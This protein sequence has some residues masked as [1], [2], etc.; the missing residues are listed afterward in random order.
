M[1]PDDADFSFT[2]DFEKGAGDPRR[3][4]DAASALVD[5]FESI[6][7]ALVNVLDS[8][9]KTVVVLEDVES[10][11]LKV[12]LRNLLSG[13]PDESLKS[14]EWKKAVGHYL[15]KA[16]YLALEFCNDETG[17][18]ERLDLLREQI[19]ELGRD[20]NIRHLPDYAPIHEGRLLASLDQ[21]QN[22]KRTL[23]PRD[24]LY[25]QLDGKS[26]EV[27]LTKTRLPSEDTKVTEIGLRETH[28]EGEAILAIRKPDLLGSAMWQFAHGKTNISA[29]IRDDAWLNRFHDRK[30]ALYSGD[31]LNC[32]VRFTYVYDENGNLIEQKTEVLKVLDI[33]KGA[34]PQLGFPI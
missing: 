33:L 13:I 12:W 8:Q 27:D 29:P 24:K 31:A 28:S 17:G 5:A 23:G 19:R 26:F 4:F 11:S 25:V 22:A 9:L 14:I 7:K 2:I 18:K 32:K 20:T 10:G 30:I 21:V 16:K 34:G 6:D 15:V 1:P 3:V